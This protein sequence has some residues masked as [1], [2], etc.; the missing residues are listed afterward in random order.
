MSETLD[1]WM[2]IKPIYYWFDFSFR[3]HLQSHG[4]SLGSEGFHWVLG[5]CWGRQG[6][7]RHWA[8]R[9]VWR[10]PSPHPY[11]PG[12]KTSFGVLFSRSFIAAFAMMLFRLILGNFGLI[13]ETTAKAGELHGGRREGKVPGDSSYAAAL[14]P[15]VLLHL[16]LHEGS[17]RPPRKSPRTETE[18]LKPHWAVL[19]SRSI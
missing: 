16:H 19:L 3:S 14:R 12:E 2:V 17:H 6:L 13:P 5:Q 8:H 9:E 7:R 18:A 10:T 11:W 4:G 1:C 15:L